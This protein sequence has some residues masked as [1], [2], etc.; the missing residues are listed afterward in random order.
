MD[1]LNVKRQA[2]SS[3][4]ARSDCYGYKVKTIDPQVNWDMAWSYTKVHTY[5]N[6]GKC[7]TYTHSSP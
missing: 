1:S 2:D 6:Y 7:W 3:S 4:P 5:S